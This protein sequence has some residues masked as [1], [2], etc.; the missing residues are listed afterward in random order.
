MDPEPEPATVNA[1]ARRAV[2]KFALGLGLGLSLIESV[3]GQDLDPRR[4]RPQRGDRFVLPA[5]SRDD[6]MMTPSSVPRGGPPVTAYPVDPKTGVV[7]SASRLN[8][9]DALSRCPRQ[10]N[11]SHRSSH[12]PQP[13]KR[14]QPAEVSHDTSPQARSFSKVFP[15]E[16]RSTTNSRK[17][18]L[19]SGWMTR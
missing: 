10:S 18:T 16:F 3:R 12:R 11:S 17:P 19:P 13:I 6:A 2:L 14:K 7:R 1:K 8:P 9:A 15:P 5:G 4:A